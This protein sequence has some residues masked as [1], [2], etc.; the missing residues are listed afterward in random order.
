[1]IIKNLINERMI[2][3]KYYYIRIVN[4]GFI[5]ILSK[6]MRGYEFFNRFARISI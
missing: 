4:T 1:M 3:S 6:V 5:S 2:C